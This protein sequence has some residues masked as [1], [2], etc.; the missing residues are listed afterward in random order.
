VLFADSSPLNPIKYKN[1][2]ALSL[3]YDLQVVND[4]K[5]V[6]FYLFMVRFLV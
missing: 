3:D 4:E 2:F 1:S 6:Y 5:D